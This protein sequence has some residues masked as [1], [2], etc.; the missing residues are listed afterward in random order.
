MRII[1]VRSCYLCPKEGF[2]KGKHWCSATLQNKVI[3]EEYHDA[4]RTMPDWCPLEE[5][6]NE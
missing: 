5:E 4:D 2:D 1:K 3:D 6:S